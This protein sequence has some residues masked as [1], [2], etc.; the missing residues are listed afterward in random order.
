MEVRLSDMYGAAN[1]NN[2]GP[3]LSAPVALVM[4]I[5]L[6]YFST[7]S[8]SMLGIEKGELPLNFLS[9]NTLSLSKL[10]GI[11]VFFFIFEATDTRNLSNSDEISERFSMFC[12][13][14]LI[15]TFWSSGFMLWAR[16]CQV[17]YPERGQVL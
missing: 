1:F 11:I 10:E 14:F 16:L 17:S 5:F 4:S 2:L 3:I 15:R 8:Y 7:L 12:H 9:Q 13:H 6:M